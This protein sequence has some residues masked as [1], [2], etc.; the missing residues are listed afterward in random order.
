MF[1]AAAFGTR[2]TGPDSHRK[3]SIVRFVSA[4]VVLAALAFAGPA[5]ADVTFTDTAG[6]NPAA[7]DINTVTVANNP[8]TETVSFKVQ[9][10]NMPTLTEDN[11]AIEIYMDSDNNLSTGQQG[12]DCIFGVANTGWYFLEWDGT[13][14][15]QVTGLGLS[16]SYDGGLMSMTMSQG[17]CNIGSAFSFWVTSY[18]GP[19]PNNPVTDDAPDGDALYSYTLVSAP[20]TLSSETVVV[21]AKPRTSATFMVTGFTVSFSDGTSR[22]LLGVKCTATLGGR[23]I[24]GGGVG[25]CSFLIPKHAKGKRLVVHVSGKSPTAVY[26]KTVTYTVR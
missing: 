5:Y 18:R 23:R 21:N 14:Y 17:D 16:V 11:A 12:V 6:E 3:G 22:Y 2:R 25:G 19:D 13:K 26:R 7:A 8:T 15:T 20:P 9:I 10:A 1:T 4:A 24:A